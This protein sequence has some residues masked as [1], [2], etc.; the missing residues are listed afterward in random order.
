MEPTLGFEPRTCCLRNSCSTAE[1]CRRRTR[2]ADAHGRPLFVLQPLF[3]PHPPIVG[4][5]L[6]QTADHGN[7][8]AIHERARE[9]PRLDR[10]IP[11]PPPEAASVTSSI[12]SARRNQPIAIGTARSDRTGAPVGARGKVRPGVDP[13]HQRGVVVDSPRRRTARCGAI[14]VASSPTR[15]PRCPPRRRA[16]T[17]A[18]DAQGSFHAGAGEVD[19]VAAQDPHR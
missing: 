7:R 16:T 15:P 19:Q 14:H 8:G 12:M 13:V 1:L 11:S 10:R 2:I 18:L 3:G 6:E 17:S 5:A 4:S 9:R